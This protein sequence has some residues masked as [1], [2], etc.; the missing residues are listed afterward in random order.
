MNLEKS[1]RFHFPKSSRISDESPSTSEETLKSS[2]VLAAIGMA[3]QEAAFGI[4]AFY[5][6]MDVSRMDK[7]QAV[8]V[9]MKRVRAMLIRGKVFPGLEGRIRARIIYLIAL[10]SYEAYCRTAGSPEGRCSYCKGRGTVL[11]LDLTEKLNMR[12]VKP[13]SRCHGL[14]YKP[15]RAS[16]LQRAI[17]AIFPDLSQASFSRHIKPIFEA[18]IQFCFQEE[19]RAE[20][21][22]HKATK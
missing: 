3:Q 4:C 14:G 16:Q 1:V 10:F 6:K 13:C 12:V 19:S 11:D 7:S 15:V 8:T 2:D 5:G 20:S 9:L 22:L 18:M 17:K 21:A